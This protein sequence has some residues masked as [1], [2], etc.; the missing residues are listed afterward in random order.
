MNR[1]R[2]ICSLIFVSSSYLFSQLPNCNM[3][4]FYQSGVSNGCIAFGTSGSNS[5]TVGPSLGAGCQGLAI[6]P[7]FGFP[8]PNPTYWSV[9][10]MSGTYFYFNGSTWVNTGHSAGGAGFT[11]P[12]A[13]QNVI[14]NINSSGQ[15]S[16]Y[17]GT[18]N[19][20]ILTTLNDF[21]SANAVSDVVADNNNN[22][23]LLKFSPPQCLAVFNP[24]GVMTCS[25]SIQ[26]LT[27]SGSGLGISNNKVTV[28]SSTH[29][30]GSVIGGTVNFIQNPAVM[31]CQPNDLATCPAETSIFPEISAIPSKTITCVSPN[32]TLTSNDAQGINSYTWSGPGVLSPSNGHSIV[33]NAS[34]TYTRITLNC[35]GQVETRTFVVVSNL[36][37]SLTVVASSSVMCAGQAP[38]TLT[39]GGLANYTW[40]PAASLSSSVSPIVAA[41]PSLTTTYT[42][43]ASINGCYA[44]TVITI[45]AQQITQTTISAS[46]TSI[47]AGAT[48][49]LSA[50][51]TLTCLWFP[52]SIVGHSIA[53]TPTVSTSYTLIEVDNINCT[54]T[55]SISINVFNQPT[56]SV[57]VSTPSVCAGNS[58]TIFATGA[59]AFVYQPGNLTGTTVTVA[60]MLSTVFTVTGSNWNCLDSKTILLSVEALP[61]TVIT[62]N[63]TLVCIGESLILQGNGADTYLWSN[64]ATGSTI[65][66]SP[67]VNTVYT[68]TG[69]NQSGCTNSAS[70]TVHVSECTVNTSH[71][72]LNRVTFYPNPS[73][74][75]LHVIGVSPGTEATLILVNAL[76]QSIQEQ[77]LDEGS[78]Q[79]YFTNCSPGVY[80]LQIRIGEATEVLGRIIF[81]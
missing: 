36:N 31:W 24:Q 17:N 28:L 38:I 33:V 68:L 6:G 27:S 56:I 48:V 44:S 79:A 63:Q 16:V 47:C 11:N 37:P 64:N 53:V 67:L 20:A 7:N 81:N 22:F 72:T 3:G 70:F 30:T 42:V 21:N 45:S 41:S 35:I 9:G 12:G 78:T 51:G 80:L 57:S 73:N 23:Y 26:G 15:I 62:S 74:G 40:S 69:T 66:V 32:L 19:A 76:G 34:G 52:G 61:P 46:S 60:P 1:I 10:S 25:Y 14:Y 58:A 43:Q 77:R 18:S 13:G 39:V 49:T 4:Y 5:L 29:L 54:N 50:S 65:V 75:M 2:H 59:G 71:L 8:A 55:S